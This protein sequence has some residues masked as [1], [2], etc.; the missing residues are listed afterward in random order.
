MESREGQIPRCGIPPGNGN[1]AGDTGGRD[2]HDAHEALIP[3]YS[4]V[5]WEV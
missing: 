2:T 3:G 4:I 1:D 5:I